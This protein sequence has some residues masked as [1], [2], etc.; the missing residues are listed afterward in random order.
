[1]C[2]CVYTFHPNRWWDVCVCVVFSIQ[3][4]CHPPLSPLFAERKE[5]RKQVCYERRW[6]WWW[7]HSSALCLVSSFSF[8]FLARLSVKKLSLLLCSK[9]HSFFSSDV[10]AV[11]QS[12]RLYI[13]THTHMRLSSFNVLFNVL[14]QA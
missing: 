13:Y 11:N 6:W 8:L 9:V 10:Y 12:F 5:R 1:M 2:R 3:P 4:K 7:W 14:R